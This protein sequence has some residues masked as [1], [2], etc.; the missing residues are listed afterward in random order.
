MNAY[1]D[2]SFLLSLYSV[3]AHSQSAAAL[4]RQHQPVFCLTPFLEAEFSNA[5]ELGVFVKRYTAREAR[6]VR[7]YF[8]S[9]IRSGVFRACDFPPDAYPLARTLSSRHT[10]KL[11]TRALDVLHVASALVLKAEVFFTFDQRQ[12]RLA[13]AE[14]LR[15]LP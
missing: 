11:G 10:A 4:V 7:D 12:Q 9:H 3:D 2:S 1:A 5:V 13:R 14:G 8:L 15:L 6:A